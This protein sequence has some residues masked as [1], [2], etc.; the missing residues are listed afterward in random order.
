MPGQIVC[1][2]C[3]K[4]LNR[5][6]LSQGHQCRRFYYGRWEIREEETVWRP[7]DGEQDQVAGDPTVEDETAHLKECPFCNRVSLGFNTILLLWECL[8]TQCRARV[9]NDDIRRQR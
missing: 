6:D 9:A 5:W 3:G 4:I 7:E 8:N 1:A 2:R